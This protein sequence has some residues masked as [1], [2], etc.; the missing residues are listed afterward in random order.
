MVVNRPLMIKLSPPPSPYAS[1]KQAA[2]D[3]EIGTH[4][5]Q[6]PAYPGCVEMRRFH[7]RKDYLEALQSAAVSAKGGLTNDI[8]LCMLVCGKV[9]R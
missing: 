7:A 3:L 8:M 1:G 5:A 2:G 9:E 4:L 6:L